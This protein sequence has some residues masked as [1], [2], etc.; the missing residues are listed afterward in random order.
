MEDRDNLEFMLQSFLQ[1]LRDIATLP[2]APLAE[3]LLKIMDCV[4]SATAL[5][6]VR[7]VLFEDRLR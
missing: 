3:P 4:P 6:L 2:A 7:V 5:N 1:I